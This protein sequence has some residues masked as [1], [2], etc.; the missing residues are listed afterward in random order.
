[1]SSSINNLYTGWNILFGVLSIV[2]L[3]FVIK[4]HD[5]KPDSSMDCSMQL[6]HID[7]SL[8]ELLLSVLIA[9]ILFTI[10]HSIVFVNTNNTYNSVCRN[11]FYSILSIVY[12]VCIFFSII[13]IIKFKNNKDCYNF[14][15]D[16]NEYF[17]KSFV[18]M[19]GVFVFE[20]L[21]FIVGVFNICCCSKSTR[22]K[23]YVVNDYSRI[24]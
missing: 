10:I 11:M 19:C 22:D 16:N 17:F 18:I 5:V 15:K 6:I 1:M 13:M 9:R 12:G 24:Y 3:G 20:I 23:D 4:H 21:W 2:A 8:C 7:Y 14:Y